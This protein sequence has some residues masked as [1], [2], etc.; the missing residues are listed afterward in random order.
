MG[1]NSFILIYISF[2]GKETLVLLRDQISDPL[3]ELINPRTQWMLKKFNMNWKNIEF[4]S[5][6]LIFDLC[7]SFVD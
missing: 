7:Q 6:Y 2:H 1:T 4:V 3:R 5:S